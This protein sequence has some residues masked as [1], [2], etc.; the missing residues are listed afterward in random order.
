EPYSLSGTCEDLPLNLTEII[1]QITTDNAVLISYFESENDAVQ[2]QNPI[3]SFTEYLP[4]TNSG[5]LYVRLE[6]EEHCPVVLPFVFERESLP[7]NPFTSLPT[8]CSGNE[9]LLDAGEEFPD[10]NYEWNW[11]GGNSIGSEFTITEPGT[12]HL[13][14]TTDAGC[15]DTF[16]LLIEQ[17]EPPAITNILIGDTYIIVET[18]GN[19]TALEFSLDGVFWQSNPRFDNL[20]PG[21]EYTVYVR[22]SGCEPITKTVSILYITNFISPNGDGKNDTWSIRG[23]NNSEECSVKIFDRYGK[24]FVDS[25][26]QIFT[27]YNWNGKYKG[28]TVPSGDYWYIITTRNEDLVEMKY[29]GHISVRNR[30]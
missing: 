20:T 16:D 8:L 14:I 25:G 15:S 7:E 26:F 4:L 19:G 28:E 30:D 21:E 23:F 22:E 12:Y 9:I 13:T 3:V 11:E 2:N 18:S 10:E 17:P 27:D 6:L 5:T 1:P 29:I 24:I